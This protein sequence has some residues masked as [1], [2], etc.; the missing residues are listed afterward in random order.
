MGNLRIIA[1]VALFSFSFMT[2]CEMDLFDGEDDDS[3]LVAKFSD[4][5]GPIQVE[6]IVYGHWKGTNHIQGISFDQNIL[7]IATTKQLLMYSMDK[8]NF[9][10]EQQCNGL[11]G[12]NCN[13]FHF[14]DPAFNDG[15]FW[16]PLSISKYWKRDYSCA[17]N[18]LLQFKEGTIEGINNPTSYPLDYP[19]HIGAVEILNDKVYV[20]G[21]DINTDWP[22]DDNCHEDQI[23]YVY[24]KEDLIEN[25][26]NVHYD[27]LSFKAHGKNGIQNLA[28]FDQENL[29]VTAYKCED[30]PDNYVYLLNIAT[31][32]HTIYRYENWAYGVAKNDNGLLYFCEDNRNTSVIKINAI[33]P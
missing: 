4:T 33:A 32:A 12:E 18:K 20:A 17:Q 27:V 5:I 2:S 28:V 25:A 29:L 7:Y 6:E 13:S 1:L 22:H 21:K 11:L 23:I 31:G 14:G 10:E 26:C 24:N 30:D 15:D 19:G 8:N 9:I 16:V 3:N